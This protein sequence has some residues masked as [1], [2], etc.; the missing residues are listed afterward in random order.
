MIDHV[1]HKSVVEW[2]HF[3]SRV[4]RVIGMWLVLH[5]WVVGHRSRGSW[6]VR[7]MGHG[8][9]GHGSCGSWVIGHV[10]HGSCGSWIHGSW[11]M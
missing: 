11:F 4:S 10:G 8:S 2:V 5:A 9:M 1:R 6:V 7:V 3:G